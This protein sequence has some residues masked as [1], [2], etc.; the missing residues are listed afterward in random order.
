VRSLDDFE[1]WLDQTMHFPEEVM[2]QAWKA[3]PPE[4]IEDEEYAVAQLLD[5]LFERRK[6]L[7]ELI[8]ACRQARAN[9]FPNWR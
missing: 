4:W 5:R 9:P 7:P 2:D 3:I 1:P 8:A 6:L